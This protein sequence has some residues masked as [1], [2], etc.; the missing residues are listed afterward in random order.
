MATTPAD[1]VAVVSIP[2]GIER[3]TR[4]GCPLILP[5]TLPPLPLIGPACTHAQPFTRA[6]Y[7]KTPGECPV[8]KC[9]LEPDVVAIDGV[10][11][12]LRRILT[13]H[14]VPDRVVVTDDGMWSPATGADLFPLSHLVADDTAVEWLNT[15]SF[16]DLRELPG[17]DFATAY[18]MMEAMP[19]EGSLPRIA[20]RFMGPF[21]ARYRNHF[22]TAVRGHRLK[23]WK[24]PSPPKESET[25]ALAMRAYNA[26][27]GTFTRETTGILA[28]IAVRMRT[29]AGDMAT[30]RFVAALRSGNVAALIA[31]YRRVWPRTT[32]SIEH[33]LLLIEPHLREMQ[34]YYR[35]FGRPV[36]ELD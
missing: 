8:C 14:S 24:T 28:A 36:M 35:V 19:I 17:V 33:H 30:S 32:E 20:T 25:N 4:P 3:I 26:S 34:A 6:E 13:T 27:A 10:T 9:S 15:L 1:S 2:K 23:I 7:V 29:E 31:L 16:Q 21:T 5:I 18:A 12:A 22:I 11:L